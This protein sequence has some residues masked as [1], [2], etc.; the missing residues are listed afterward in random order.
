EPTAPSPEFVQ[1][2][3]YSVE[4]EPGKSQPFC[5]GSHRG[6]G[7]NPVRFTVDQKKTYYLCG[8]KISDTKPFCD[9]T[10]RKE[11]GVAK[12]NEY[13]LK[14]NTKLKAEVER[15]RTTQIAL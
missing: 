6:S 14:S 12:Y 7:I 5:D 13:L 15:L 2:K 11:K 1:P 8:C 9:G 4:L 10:H 3:P